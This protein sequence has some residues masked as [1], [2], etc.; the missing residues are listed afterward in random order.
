MSLAEQA[1]L[2][3]IMDGDRSFTGLGTAALR[4]EALARGMRPSAAPKADAH[5]PQDTSHAD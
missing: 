5:N 1:I 4:Q 2:Q 3:S